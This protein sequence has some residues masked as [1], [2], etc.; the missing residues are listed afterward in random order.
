MWLFDFF[1]FGLTERQSLEDAF[2]TGSSVA[3]GHDLTD[4]STK[5]AERF[6]ARP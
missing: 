6:G 2:S 5:K 4:A 1:L 3:A